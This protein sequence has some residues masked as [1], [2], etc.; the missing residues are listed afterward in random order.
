MK[1]FYS[2]KDLYVELRRDVALH[3]TAV[4]ASQP[5]QVISVRMMAQF[6]GRETI[7]K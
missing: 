7:Y 3:I 4:I 5:F 6:I 2:W 1:L